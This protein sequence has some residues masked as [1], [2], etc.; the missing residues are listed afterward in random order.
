MLPESG[1]LLRGKVGHSQRGVQLNL[2]SDRDLRMIFRGQD[3]L[4][5]LKMEIL[6]SGPEVELSKMSR[7]P[8][9]NQESEGKP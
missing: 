3:V 2:G 5:G 7:A 4:F 9:S 1:T 8:R 6:R